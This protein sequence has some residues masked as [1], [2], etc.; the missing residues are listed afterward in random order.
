MSTF[1]GIGL[2]PLR[3]KYRIYIHMVLGC[4]N[5]PTLQNV[6]SLEKSSFIIFSSSPPVMS[7]VSSFSPVFLSYAVA[8]SFSSPKFLLFFPKQ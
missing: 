3:E 8:T 6:L 7:S 2:L 1:P 4:K 5:M